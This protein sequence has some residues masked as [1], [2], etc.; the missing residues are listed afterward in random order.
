M[1]VGNSVFRQN[2][3]GVND[4]AG[5]SRLAQFMQESA[6][7]HDSRRRLQAETDVRQAHHRMALGK[8]L[9][10]KP[11]AFDGFHGVGAVGLDAG[12]DRQHQ[13]IE[14]DVFIAQSVLANG[15]VADA[16]GDRELAL[17][18]A[19]HRVFLVFVDAPGD[20]RRAVFA[21]HV[22]DVAEPFLAV[23]E[24]HRVENAAPAG[25]FQAR[26]HDGGIGAVEHEGHARLDLA[27]VAP[28][29]LVHVTHA[30]AAHEI[31]AD[32][33]AMRPFAHFIAGHAD[34]AV[35]IIGLQ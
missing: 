7:Q 5:Q 13:R 35:P 2:F 20:D 15:Q 33:Q 12:R 3:R 6:I 30:I 23:F 32:I 14:H 8:L 29:D 19:G 9:A 26:F 31:N 10:D 22:A 1:L 11:S 28:N 27:G 25:Q 18:R 21:G 16:R 17:A 34:Q 24:V 4:G